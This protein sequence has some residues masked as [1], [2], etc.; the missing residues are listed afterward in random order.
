MSLRTHLQLASALVTGLL[1]GRSGLWPAFDGAALL[2]LR[3]D[4]A[5]RV[6]SGRRGTR[7][8]DPRGIDTRLWATARRG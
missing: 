4:F 2:G 3:P 6:R 7:L 8:L 5:R 1:R